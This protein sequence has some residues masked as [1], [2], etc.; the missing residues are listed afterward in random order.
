MS[1][2]GP[3]LLLED[4]HDDRDFMEK[5]FKELEIEN[6]RVYLKNAA[7]ALEY[8]NK[9]SK[10]LFVILCD[11]NLPG[12]NGLEIKREIDN[13]PYLRLKSIPFVF[14]STSIREE[15][16]VEAYTE[17]TVQGFFKK[18]ND[19]TEAKNAIAAICAY[20]K[21]CRHPNA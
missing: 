4:D 17:L 16:V 9:T 8:L 15:Q 21:L 20:W 2:S 13:N 12:L 14:Y 19:F 11:V 10:S 6:E 1:K 3:I 7:E 18:E 5:I